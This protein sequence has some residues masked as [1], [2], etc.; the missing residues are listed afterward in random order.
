MQKPTRNNPFPVMEH[1]TVRMVREYL[2]QKKSIIIPVG[3]IE[4]H[5][6]H[7]PLNT[8]ALV[9]THVSRM[10][11]E[12][13]GILVG[14][15][16]YQSF[17]GGALPGTIN[18]SPAVMS[19]VVSDTLISLAGQGFRNFYLL[20]GHGGSENDRALDNALKLLLRTNP[21]LSN[22]MIALLPE[23]KFGREL[24]GGWTDALRE[25]DWHAGWL[26][27]S[28]VMAVEPGLVRMDELELDPEPLLDLQI[29]H[30]DNYQHAEK[31]VDD[32]FVVARMT[33]R[34]DIKVGVMGHPKKASP[35]LGRKII[36]SMVEGASEKI[37]ELESKADGVYKEVEFTP[38]P[39][40][41]T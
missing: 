27:T 24:K 41:L 25:H 23:W 9:A 28:M 32:E 19:L 38:D 37:I 33:Q 30:P 26:E 1:M 8:D 40:L 14:P 5:G 35:E 17:S 6:Y 20:L 22:A 12:R 31:I 10:I 2:E 39:I 11:G 29:E 15:T 36:E 21:T 3:V 13:T 18:I 7:L 34:P 4:Q 16:M